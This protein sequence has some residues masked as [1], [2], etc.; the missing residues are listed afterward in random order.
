MKTDQLCF[1]SSDMNAVECMAVGEIF[2]LVK[3]VHPFTTLICYKGK[4]SV[5]VVVMRNHSVANP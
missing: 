4:T 1:Y 5:I 3:L 2:G